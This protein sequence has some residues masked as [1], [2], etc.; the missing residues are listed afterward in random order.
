MTGRH[1][2]AIIKPH[3]VKENK[4]G[5]IIKIINEAGFGIVALKMIRLT[6]HQTELF[7]KV[8]RG[9]EFFNPLA[10]M[11]SSGPVIALMLE[12]ENA[13][14]DLRQIIGNTDPSIAEPGTIRSLYG[15]SMRENAIHAS[16]SDESAR[17][18]CCFFFSGMERYP[19]TVNVP[20]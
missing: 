20:V 17:R 10:E 12:K 15:N 4:T 16:D 7:Y 8:H 1:T 18:E 2:L 11:M 19:A 13:V 5:G 14:Y 3:A 6:I 9:K